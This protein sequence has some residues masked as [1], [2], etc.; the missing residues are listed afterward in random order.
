MQQRAFHKVISNRAKERLHSPSILQQIKSQ[1]ALSASKTPEDVEESQLQDYFQQLTASPIAW[2]FKLPPSLEK[3]YSDTQLL[4]NFLLLRIALILGIVFL[5]F[6][7]L[8]EGFL[9]PE[10]P[11]EIWRIR[12]PV[13]VILFA[14]WLATNTPIFRHKHQS[15]LSL[16]L[17]LICTSML[18]G[19][20]LFPIEPYKTLNYIV[21]A[22]IQL[23]GYTATPIRSIN[24]LR[25][26]TM[27]S[28]ITLFSLAK[29]E[30]LPPEHWIPIASIYLAG[31]FAALLLAF[32]LERINLIN[33][34]QA[35][36]LNIEKVKL[37]HS[38]TQLKN[39]ATT[40]ALT[41]ISN[42]REFNQALKF[43]WNRATRSGQPLSLL[44][45]D[46]DFFKQ[47]NDT[48]GHQMGDVCLIEV[49]KALTLA[50]QRSGDTAFRFGGEEF[51]IV[52][53]GCTEPE[54]LNYAEIIRQTIESLAI[55]HQNSTINKHVTC[56]IGGASWTVRL[57][58][59]QESFIKTA[60]QALYRAKA[61]GKNC[62]S[63]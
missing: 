57:T 51:V 9:L 60:D 39:L 54:L 43:E 63:L 29:L 38:N 25:V 8:L 23:V 35:T 30:D 6:A 7:Q 52:V 14:T 37:H 36:R 58:D 11:T 13:V 28:C 20:L 62:V 19:A 55:P 34:I 44:F 33:F 18:A 42:R 48:Y 17:L 22:L 56:S 4:Q 47:Y 61:K 40:D 2:G 5:F 10:M 31:S 12:T 49:A 50:T 21:I 27:I 53:P 24:A 3:S 46:L 15:I 59:T 16:C 1:L 41:G 45:L 26:S 32:Q